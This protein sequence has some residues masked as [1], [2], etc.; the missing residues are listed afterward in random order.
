[1]AAYRSTPVFD[2][3]TLPAGLRGEHRTKA[4]VWGAI[5]VLEGRLRL[6]FLD[7]PSEVILAPG[8]PGLVLPDQ[9]HSVAPIGPVRMRVDFHDAP[10]GSAE[11]SPARPDSPE[12]APEGRDEMTDLPLTL[13][14][15][16]QMPAADARAIAE[17]LGILLTAFARRD[18]VTLARIYS[19][20]ADWVNAF[21][22]VS[23]ASARSCP[24]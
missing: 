16:E 11:P 13:D 10:P 8:L 24:T 12:E 9:A 20:D 22:S 1:M 5:H 3:T 19:D 6:T 18:A 7:P 2:E 21:G 17:T 23:A 14:G 4:G 15:L